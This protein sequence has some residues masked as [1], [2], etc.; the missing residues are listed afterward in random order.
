MGSFVIIT[1]T[2]IVYTLSCSVPSLIVKSLCIESLENGSSCATLS[3]C[4]DAYLYHL[5]LQPLS[6]MDAIANT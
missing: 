3:F 2:D 5:F 6:Y 1:F 4:T